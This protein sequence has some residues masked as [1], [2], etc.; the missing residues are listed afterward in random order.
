MYNMAT[1][2]NISKCLCIRYGI[3]IRPSID[4][5]IPGTVL[6]K[7]TSTKNLGVTFNSKLKF[8]EQCNAVVN[9][10]FIRVNLLLKRFHS[11]GR[12]LQIGLLNTFVRP[13]L[14][15]NSPLWFPYL[16]KDIKVVECVQKYFM[17]N[18]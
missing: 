17:K 3:V 2:L 4:Y 15:Y 16:K 12:N 10:G 6:Q 9:Q 5:N 8:S 7:V 1:K 18:L 13:I 11:R 14:E